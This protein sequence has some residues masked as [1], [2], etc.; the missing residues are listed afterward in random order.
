MNKFKTELMLTPKVFAKYV[1]TKKLNITGE[2]SVP[3]KFEGN[4]TKFEFNNVTIKTGLNIK[5]MW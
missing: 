5:Y 4:N 2:V 3:V 1:P